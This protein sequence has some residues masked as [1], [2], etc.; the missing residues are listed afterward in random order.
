MQTYRK[1]S[2]DY[3]IKYHNNSHRYHNQFTFKQKNPTEIITVCEKSEHK[4]V[5]LSFFRL[6]YLEINPI[7]SVN[8]V[9][10]PSLSTG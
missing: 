2:L 6:V 7:I 10:K 1:F 4:P 8:P 5:Q 3:D 9:N